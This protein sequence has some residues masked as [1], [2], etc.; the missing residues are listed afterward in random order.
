MKKTLVEAEVPLLKLYEV[1]K[2]YSFGL[3]TNYWL[4]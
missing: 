2:L 3:L 4:A 1:T